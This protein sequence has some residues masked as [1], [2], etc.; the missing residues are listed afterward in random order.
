MRQGVID[1]VVELQEFGERV[2]GFLSAPRADDQVSIEDATAQ[3][4]QSPRV[5]VEAAPAIALQFRAA[6]SH[7]PRSVCVF[8]TVSYRKHCPYPRL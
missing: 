2:R 1:S 7:R 6:T 3:S 5:G 8:V 4:P